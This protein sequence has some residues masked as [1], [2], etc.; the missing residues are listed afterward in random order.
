MI[1]I[2]FSA[3]GLLL[4]QVG[5]PNSLARRH[6]GRK[7]LLGAR[8]E[9]PDLPQAVSVRVERARRASANLQESLPAFFVLAVLILMSG[10][11]AEESAQTTAAIWVGL[12]V[13][14]LFI[15]LAGW[16]TIRTV[17]W[18]LSIACLIRMA[19]LLV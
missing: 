11:A 7:W 10:S 4:A 2:I 18:A 8:D 1:I 12:R 3:L 14:Y 16:Q 13:A 6:A 5:L 15:Y 17:V 9:K 19:L